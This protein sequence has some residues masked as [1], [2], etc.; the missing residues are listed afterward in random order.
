[1]RARRAAP[2]LLLAVSMA[3]CHA[4]L[5]GAHGGAEP[6]ADAATPGPAASED[7]G[8]VTPADLAAPQDLARP[9]ADL[10]AACPTGPRDCSPGPG[11][12]EP[13]TCKKLEP[14]F[15]PAVVKVLRDHPDSAPAA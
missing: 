2:G 12:G 6:A 15:F 4:E 8:T 10:A 7:A 14:C 13:D 3:S 9:T 11:S 5:E 1:M